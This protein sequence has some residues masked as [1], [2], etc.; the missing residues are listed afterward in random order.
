MFF[1]AVWVIL[2]ILV[3]RIRVVMLWTGLLFTPAVPISEY[4]QLKDYWQP[5]YLINLGT[6][7]WRFGLEDCLLAFTFAG[8][9]GGIFEI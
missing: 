5:I 7:N 8:I 1:V 9:S 6:A 2:F 4:W 3:P